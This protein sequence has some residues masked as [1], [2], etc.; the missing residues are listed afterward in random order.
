MT[1]SWLPGYSLFVCM[2]WPLI[3]V[4]KSY[5]DLHRCVLCTLL[6]LPVLNLPPLPPIGGCN[7]SL[8][9]ESES[10]ENEAEGDNSL[11]QVDQKSGHVT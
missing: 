5:F 2:V 3:D 4:P 9:G 8:S 7:S 6:Y 10:G 1:F 11:A